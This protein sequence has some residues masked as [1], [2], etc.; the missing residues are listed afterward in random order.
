MNLAKICDRVAGEV[1]ANIV[2]VP[3][4]AD[5]ARIAGEVSIPVYAQGVDNVGYGSHTGWILPESVKAA[6]ASGC[7]LNHSEHGLLLADVDVLVGRLR[8]LGLTSIVCTNNI[9]VTKAAAV[10]SPD[11]VAVE[12]PELIG[13]GI[14]VS[15]AK[16]EVVTESVKA[17][18]EVNSRVKVLCGAGITTGEDVRKAVELG[19]CGV[20]LASGVVK[21]KDPE[22]AL[23]DLIK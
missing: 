17:V 13:S 7:L 5:L 12:P 22:K 3:Q 15:E 20:L 8:G 14:P 18:R 2:V 4:T 23:R 11:Y 6:G 19:T 21:A 9:L 1:G 10:L 16:P